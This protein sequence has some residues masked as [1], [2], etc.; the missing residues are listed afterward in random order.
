MRGIQAKKTVAQRMGNIPAVHVLLL[1]QATET[2]S[3]SSLSGKETRPLLEL[4]GSGQSVYKSLVVHICNFLMTLDD[5]PSA[6]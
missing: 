1:L 5:F 3:L 6:D 2:F 4:K